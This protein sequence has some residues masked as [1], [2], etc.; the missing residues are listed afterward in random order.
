MH[1]SVDIFFQEYEISYLEDK[2]KKRK[3]KFFRS[4]NVAKEKNERISC[5]PPRMFSLFS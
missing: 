1:R 3:I 5:S 2:V 4:P